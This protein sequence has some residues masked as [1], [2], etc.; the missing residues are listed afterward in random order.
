MSNALTRPEITSLLVSSLTP[1]FR[2]Q[3]TRLRRCRLDGTLKCCEFMRTGASPYQTITVPMLGVLAIIV[4]VMY[5]VAIVE[6]YTHT[7]YQNPSHGLLI[8]NNT[9]H[10]TT[11]SSFSATSS[12][13]ATSP[14]PSPACATWPWPF[15]SPSRSRR[16]PP[17]WCVYVWANVAHRKGRGLTHSIPSRCVQVKNLVTH[18]RPN[19]YALIIYA[20]LG[21]VD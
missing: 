4:P 1:T 14:R 21:R 9:H 12:C 16:R 3:C 2:A 5:V 11:A 13:G 20:S 17:T 19:H 10:V 7:I 6:W 8:H 18:P 15:S